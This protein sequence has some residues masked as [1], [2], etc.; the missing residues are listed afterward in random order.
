MRLAVIED[1]ELLIEMLQVQFSVLIDTTFFEAIT[2]YPSLGKARLGMNN[3]RPD[4]ILCDVH[5]PDGRAFSETASWLVNDDV[6]LICMTGK[7]RMPYIDNALRSGVLA[8]IEKDN[9]FL[10][11]LQDALLEASLKLRNRQQREYI[12][13]HALER[14]ALLQEALEAAQVQLAVKNETP[15]TFIIR[16]GGETKTLVLSSEDILAAESN[17]YKVRLVM[18]D[19]E[20]R[21]EITKS[22][23]TL[24]KLLPSSAH[25]LRCHAM[26]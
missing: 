16:V 25:F 23:T 15:L 24:E 8:F 3:F 7:S 26:T 1:D 12:V 11:N 10:L 20:T 18:G 13:Y 6:P 5:L 2:F 22:L 17:D 9:D 19:G 14:Q 4:V 21:Y